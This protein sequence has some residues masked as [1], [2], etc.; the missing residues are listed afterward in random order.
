MIL[1]NGG[2]GEEEEEER[3]RGGGLVCKKHIRYMFKPDAQK[4]EG[5]G[6]YVQWEQITVGGE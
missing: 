3:K 4:K 1:R 6:G 5:G 2:V